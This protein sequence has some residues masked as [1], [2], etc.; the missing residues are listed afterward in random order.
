MCTKSH[1]L[2]CHRSA[3]PSPLQE[4][5]S[6][7]ALNSFNTSSTCSPFSSGQKSHLN[8]AKIELFVQWECVNLAFTPGSIDSA[9][10]ASQ[11]L[12]SQLGSALI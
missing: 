8:P 9:A 11:F 2:D 12:S 6:P 10:D 7:A 4:T 3:G 1:P 5:H